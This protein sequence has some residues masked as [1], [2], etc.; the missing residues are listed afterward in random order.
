MYEGPVESINKTEVKFGNNTTQK[1]TIQKKTKEN[2]IKNSFQ[3][4]SDQSNQIGNTYLTSPKNTMSDEN[5]E[6]DILRPVPEERLLN[7]KRSH[8]KESLNSSQSIDSL[9]TLNIGRWTDSEHEK[10]LEA[11]LLFGNEWKLVQTHIKTR[12]S[13]QARSHAQK[14]FLRLKKN[15]KISDDFNNSAFKRI[16]CFHT[17]K[18]NKKSKIIL[19]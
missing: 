16:N 19:I 12:S 9:E 8:S 13:T 18:D 17:Q 3:S 2:I 1:F 4:E 15:I 11:I 5:I 7:Q 6:D 14:F 10:F